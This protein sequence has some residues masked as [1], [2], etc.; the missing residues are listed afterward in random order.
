MY[1][2][3]FYFMLHKALRRHIHSLS[4]HASLSLFCW[5]RKRV[6]RATGR[7]RNILMIS[8]RL[9]FTSHT[10]TSWSNLNRRKRLSRAMNRSSFRWSLSISDADCFIRNSN[11]KR[12]QLSI[13]F[14]NQ[15]RNE[16]GRDATNV[17]R[18]LLRTI[19]SD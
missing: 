9:A 7:E 10:S 6:F 16:N 1:C 18:K 13:K 8:I 14:T 19:R 11:L 5:D 2:L 12:S 17:D 15:L 3:F 4:Y